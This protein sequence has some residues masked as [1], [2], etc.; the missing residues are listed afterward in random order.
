MS[1]SDTIELFII[2]SLKNENEINVQRNE[3]ANF[4][5]CSPSQINYV[6]QTRFS[7]SRG[8]VISSRKG[9]GGYVK[10]IRLSMQDNDD[11]IDLITCKIGESIT[12]KEAKDIVIRLADVGHINKRERLIIQAAVSDKAFIDAYNKD[13]VRANTLK[14]VLIELLS[15]G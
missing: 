6:L 13:A 8:Y 15:W 9:G 10:I 2:D 14:A 4:F 1:V 5:G 7:V 3:L 11:I 12:A